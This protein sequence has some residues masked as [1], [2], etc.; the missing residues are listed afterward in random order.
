[1][2]GWTQHHAIYKAETEE[3]LK[4]W[5]DD[6]EKFK[7]RND[8][9]IARLYAHFGAKNNLDE[10]HIA[11][12][13]VAAVYICRKLAAIEAGRERGVVHTLAGYEDRKHAMFA[14]GVYSGMQEA[15]KREDYSNIVEFR[16]MPQVVAAA[17]TDSCLA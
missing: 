7:R 6:P 17:F 5:H 10:M 11:E 14:K 2:Q 12:A 9:R 1:M 8:K 3:C 15:E 4:Q 16:T 13:L